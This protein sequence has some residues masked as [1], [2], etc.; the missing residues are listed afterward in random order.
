MNLAKLVITLLSS[1]LIVQSALAAHPNNDDLAHAHHHGSKVV[2]KSIT[3]ACFTVEIE[4]DD[5]AGFNLRLIAKG[6]RFQSPVKS[7]QPKEKSEYA[8]HAHLLVNGN[9]ITRIYS[10]YFF[11]SQSH[12]KEGLNSLKLILASDTHEN[13]MFGEEQVQA[14]ITVDTRKE[15]PIVHNYSSTCKKS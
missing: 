13:W 10:E 14:V 4:T 6:F 8:G 9:K 3:D 7:W 5:K 1:A 15:N 11:L 2:P 12:L